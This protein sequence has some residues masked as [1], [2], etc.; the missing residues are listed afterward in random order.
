VSPPRVG[1]V[2]VSYNTRDDLLRCLASLR[3][4]AGLPCEVTVVDNASADGSAE[5]VRNAYP[6][7]SLIENA[8]NVGFARACNQG[9]HGS[10]APFVLLINSDAQVL[11]GSVAIMASL[12]DDRPDVGLV[13]PRTRSGDGAIQVSFGP[14]LTPVA[15]WRQRKL[16]RGVRERRVSALARAE[17]LAAREHE[18]DWV[19]ASCLLARRQALDAVGGFDEGFFLYEEDVDLCVRMRRAGWKILFTP[20]AEVVHHLGHSMAQAPLAAR[21]AYHESHLRYYRKHR[22]ALDRAVL[23]LS[24]AGLSVAG[25]LRSLGSGDARR[26]R[27]G[28][29]GQTLRLALGGGARGPQNPLAF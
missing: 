23:R 4:D 6:D 25:W 27:R 3:T 14:D 17:A 1:A 22:G 18:P 26:Q 10:S 13:G 21:L 15:E 12:L 24:L 16:V 9:I 20:R 19:S 29:H 5:A 28:L 2:V 7:A 11:S 8:V